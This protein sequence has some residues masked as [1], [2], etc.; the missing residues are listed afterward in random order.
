[1]IENKILSWNCF[2]CHLARQAK[3]V[4]LGWKRKD[5][6][7]YCGACW[8]KLYILRAIT[9]PV[10]A[11]L[12]CDWKQLDAS[13]KVMWTRTTQMSNWIMTELFARDVRRHGDAE[14]MPPMAP[15]Y[16]YPELRI[17]WPD[18]PSQSVASLEHSIQ[19]KYRAARFDTIWTCRR[20]LPMMR[21]PVPFPVPAQGWSIK[22]E[23]ESP[24]VS[25][26][27]GEQRLKMRLKGGHPY[28]RQLQ[29]LQKMISGEAVTGEMAVLRSSDHIL[30][31]L[32]AWLPRTPQTKREGVLFVRT[33]KDSLLIALNQKDQKLWTYNADHLRRW[34]AEHSRALQR[35]AEDQKYEQRPDPS[36]AKRRVAMADKYHRRM[37]T[38]CHQIASDLAGYASRRHFAQVVYNDSDTQYHPG[39]T[40]F[41]LRKLILEKLD[42]FGIEFTLASG[43][44][45]EKT[46]PPLATDSL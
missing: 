6:L 26:R 33:D 14:K 19:K 21:Y 3:R 1:M 15:V 25:L 28:R 20:T 41:Q 46:P 8:R 12:D 24:V 29:A 11:P 42:A 4:P 10:A 43:A 17:R 9:L 30:I 34:H 44:V 35:L 37:A 16:L 23:N 13:L 38:A 22:I 27:I 2:S 31:K 39:F 36:F 5:E 32:V 7:V 45:A 40:Y 18:M